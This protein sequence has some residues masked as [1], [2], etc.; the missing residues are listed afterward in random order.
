MALACLVIAAKPVHATPLDKAACEALKLEHQTL[1]E[2]GIKDDIAHGADWANTNL[3]QS[4]VQQIARLFEV[5][6]QIAFRCKGVPLANAV[7]IR[8]LR[9]VTPLSKKAELREAAME[10]QRRGIKRS[11][12]PV[13]VQ[14]PTLEKTQSPISKT[15]VAHPPATKDTS[16]EEAPSSGPANSETAKLPKVIRLQKPKT[17]STTSKVP[18]TNA[19]Q[20]KA[21]QIKSRKARLGRSGTDT[22]VPPPPK[23]GYQPSLISP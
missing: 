23:P 18:K 12:V 3:D 10:L 13:P 15:A 17:T 5:E 22:Y 21:R 20:V 7:V 16:A 9:T 1:L 8:S 14:R 11:Y 4:R 19:R 6:E 2:T